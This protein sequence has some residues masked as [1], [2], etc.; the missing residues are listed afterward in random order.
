MN[1]SK[2]KILTNI[3][4]ARPYCMP[5]EIVDHYIQLGEYPSKAK[6]QV[7]DQCVLPVWDG[8][9][10]PDSEIRQS[11]EGDKSNA[12]YDTAQSHF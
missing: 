12:R 11:T 6:K 8:N 5:A 4:E 9:N 1:S 3:P 10:N 7:I 2:T